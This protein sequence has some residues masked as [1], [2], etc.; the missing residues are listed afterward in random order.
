MILDI[1]FNP[2]DWKKELWI[3][4]KIDVGYDEEG[5]EI[6]IYDEPKPYIFNYQPVTS[7]SEIA[8][9][10]EKVKFMKRLVMMKY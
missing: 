2:E 6:S 9:F 7:D 1:N 8:E 3:A 10:G 4:S 5:N